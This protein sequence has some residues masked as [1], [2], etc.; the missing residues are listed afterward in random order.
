MQAYF[1]DGEEVM[2]SAPG[3]LAFLEVLRESG[4]QGVH[5]IAHSMG[6]VLVANSLD[7]LHERGV[8]ERAVEEVV[9]AAPDIDAA[10]FRDHFAATLPVLA[11]R[12]ILYVSDN[13]RALQMSERFRKRPRAGQ[14]SGDT[15]LCTTSTSCEAPKTTTSTPATPPISANALPTT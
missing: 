5:I 7:R 2:L 10:P 4:F 3:F 9:L 11:R 12:I 14:R 1:G 6:N 15:R 8:R 13:D